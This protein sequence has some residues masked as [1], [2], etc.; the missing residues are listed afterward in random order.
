[1]GQSSAVFVHSRR[2]LSFFNRSH[3]RV[4][5][6]GRRRT[7]LGF[8]AV[9]I[10]PVVVAILSAA[11]LGGP[12]QN[13]TP[14]PPAAETAKTIDP[15][16]MHDRRKGFHLICHRGASEHAHENTLEAFRATFELGGDGN[17]FDIRATKDGVLIVFHDDMLDHLLAADGAV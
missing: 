16:R 6:G 11:S 12:L 17:E 15:A 3:R 2:P 10:V 1:M 8:A 4:S 13:K 5:L 9:A 7:A 14:S